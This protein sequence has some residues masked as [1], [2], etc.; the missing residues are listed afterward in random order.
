MTSVFDTRSISVTDANARGVSGLLRD[1]EAGNDVIVNRHGRPIAAVVGLDRLAEI[2][3]LEA[4][5]RSAALVLAR[6][7]TDDG[8]RDDLDDVISSLGFD[9]AQLEA[10][11]DA[12]QR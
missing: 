5:V 9:R 2:V 4:D 11:L 1:A 7:A 6:A 3:S 10:E 12:E 8:E